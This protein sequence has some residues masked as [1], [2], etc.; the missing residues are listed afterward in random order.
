MSW[1]FVKICHG[2]Y[3]DPDFFGGWWWLHE[4]LSSEIVLKIFS[5]TEL[6]S[7]SVM[8]CF[9]PLCNACFCRNYSSLD[10]QVLFYIIGLFLVKC[11]SLLTDLA[12]IVLLE[13]PSGH[14]FFF[15]SL[16]SI[17][18]AMGG[19]KECLV[20]V[21][22][23]TLHVTG[24]GSC[25]VEDVPVECAKGDWTWKG[26]GRN[27]GWQTDSSSWSIWP[28]RSF[29]LMVGGNEWSGCQPRAPSGVEDGKSD[30]LVAQLC[31]C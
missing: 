8:E 24:T 26:Q 4:V 13:N 25:S 11:V 6:K 14:W 27:S 3:A 22:S 5:H 30:A 15:N 28:W 31:P 12:C 18:L 9:M 19:C 1:D 23:S 17:H 16:E 10:E 20:P 21:F 2:W 29:V 7:Q